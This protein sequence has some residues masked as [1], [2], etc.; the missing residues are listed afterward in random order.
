MLVSVI[1]SVSVVDVYIGTAS[2][3]IRKHFVSLF[4]IRL[5]TED[6]HVL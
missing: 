6:L 4:G 1:E 3:E 2:E 5:H